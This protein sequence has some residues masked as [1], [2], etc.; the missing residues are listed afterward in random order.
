ML[1]PEKY[2]DIENK[3][4]YPI[5]VYF[6]FDSIPS[7]EKV[8]P[9]YDYERIAWG[10]KFS[11]RSNADNKH[12][13]P[14]QFATSSPTI[15]ADCLMYWN[16]RRKTAINPRIRLRY[17]ELVREYKQTFPSNIIEHSFYQE[18]ILLLISVIEDKYIYRRKEQEEAFYWLFELLGNRNNNLSKAKDALSNYVN[19]ANSDGDA[20][21]QKSLELKIILHHNKAFTESERENAFQRYTTYLESLYLPAK[22][23]LFFQCVQDFLP[24]LKKYHPALMKD[25]IFR[26]ETLFRQSQNFEPMKWQ[27]ILMDLQKAYTTYGFNN[28]AQRL[29]KDIQVATANTIQN[30]QPFSA[31]IEIPN[32]LFE[33]QVNQIIPD[34]ISL[35][36]GC[37]LGYFIPHIEK[38][39]ALLKNKQPSLLDMMTTIVHGDMGSSYKIGGLQEDLIGNL[40]R[41]MTM[42]SD[43]RAYLMH[44]CINKMQK[45]GVWSLTALQ[46]H[47]ARCP[48]LSESVI[49]ILSKALSHYFNGEYAEFCYMVVPQIEYIVRHVIFEEDGTII[50]VK[51]NNDCHQLITLGELLCDKRINIVYDIG[52]GDESV[53]VYLRFLLSETRG[54]NLRNQMCHGIGEPSVFNKESSATLLLHALL[55]LTNIKLLDTSI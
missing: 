2:E 16:E 20:Y 23:Y 40:F 21:L 54:L 3:N 52:T 39:I 24:F 4:I 55:F 42:I 15:S 53:S 31:S 51:Q 44:L 48:I 10:M 36:M 5:D 30:M 47:I 17:S 6:S 22:E 11:L 45:S 38:G 46:E 14:L 32:E 37:F 19:Q 33:L 9:D 12:F 49:R 50:K 35:Q 8:L 28:D 41:Q 27:F 26:A 29:N 43:L 18:S 25:Y 7:E 13:H 1:L 34:D